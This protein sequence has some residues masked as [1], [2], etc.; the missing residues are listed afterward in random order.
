M[1]ILRA[2]AAAIPLV[3][4]STTIA[5]AQQ[6]GE[7]LEAFREGVTVEGFRVEALYLDASERP[8]GARFIHE[9]TGFTLDLLRIQSVPQG[10]IWVRS[11]PT[12]DRGE[13]HT[14]EHLLLGKGNQ[15]RRVA[16]LETMSLGSSSAF[17]Q[18][19]RTA[20]HFNTAAGPE[21]FYDLFEQQMDALLHPDYTDEEIRREVRNFGVAEDPD[22][23]L[24][25]EEKGTVYAEMVSSFERPTSLPYRALQQAWY[26]TDHP[27]SWS[28]GGYPAAIRE[29][30]PGHIRDFHRA[31]YQLANMGMVGAYPAEMPVVGV[32]RRTGEILDRLQGDRPVGEGFMTMEELPAPRSA[33]EGEIRFVEYPHQNPQQPSALYFGWPPAL[34]LDMREQYLLELFLSGFAGDATTDL[35]RIFV[36]GTSREMETGARGVGASVSTDLGHPVWVGLFEASPGALTEARVQEVRERIVAEM[37]RIAALTD[38]SPELAAFN[39][40][41]ASR[42]IENRRWLSN[43]VDTPPGFGQRGTSST[44]IRHLDQLAREP[45]FERSLVMAE[46][47]DATESLLAGGENPWRRYL[48]EWRL[49][50]TVPYAIVARP[51]PEL[52]RREAAERRARAE[53]EIARLARHYGTADEQET[54]RRYAADYDAETARLDALAAGGT[55]PPFLEAPPLTLD[56]LLDFR[57]AEVAGMP[58]VASRFPGMTS[59]RAGIALRLDA[60]ADEDLLYLAILPTLLT[61]VG[62]VRE[63]TPIPFGEMREAL[64]REILDLS[65]SYSGNV[66]TGRTELVVRG[67]GN[68]AEEAVRAV[69]WMSEVLTAP[70]WRMENLPRI[71]D[72]VDQTLSSL[73]STT[74]RSE[75]SWVSDPLHAYRRQDDPLYLSTHSFMTRTHHAHR[76]RWRLQAEPA[77]AE[78]E[79]LRG[80]MAGLREAGEGASRAELRALAAA[81]VAEDGGNVEAAAVGGALLAHLEAQRRLPAAARAVAAE[82]ARDLE[83]TLADVPDG[84]LAS[85]WAYLVGQIAADLAVPPADALADLRRVR[86]TILDRSRARVFTIGSAEGETAVL[87]AMEPLAGRLAARPAPAVSRDPR[88]LVRSRLAARDPGAADPLFL[89]LVNPNTQGGVFLNSAP[90]AEYGDRDRETLLRFLAGRLYGGGGAHSMFMKTWAAGLAYSNGLRSSP[91]N[92]H[93]GYYAER[94]PELPQTLRFVIDELRAAPDDPD[95][96]E[97]AIAQAFTELRGALSYEARGEA[98]AA[99]LADGVTPEAVAGFRSA[100]L[101]LRGDARLAEEIFARKE[102]VNGAVLPGYGPASY[103]VEG[104]IY[105]VIGPESQMEAYQEYLRAAEPGGDTRLHRLYPRDFWIPEVATS[106]RR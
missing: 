55:K 31:N 32:L 10:F 38:G 53:A 98:I 66:R 28:A 91:A 85:D 82:V 22:G 21:V 5:P 74:Q 67:S 29:M 33:P 3:T 88:P 95:L 79:A 9:R 58:L 57:V 83:L 46:V 80:W 23:T 47:L 78:G 2:L 41:L 51:S 101:A 45:G 25:L 50:E 97:Y 49:T 52:I 105:L 8:L 27:L 70:D 35:Y 87:A 77:G 40:R 19:W 37:R 56:D 71:R 12:S 63:G 13:P 36:D 102:A 43:F 42:V 30:Q 16:D 94:V 65:A 92:G 106:D 54:I 99:D 59:A 86:E 93:L 62:V 48:A 34:D 26:G 18:G 44:W 61:Q 15:G 76:L 89:G 6:P 11:F 60:V 1:N 84:S 39:A 69:A 100:I 72:V 14:Q 64:R 104:A 96:V 75:E 73:R 81:A 17:V 103:D 68:D 7:A 20:Y 4:M 24:R 90:L